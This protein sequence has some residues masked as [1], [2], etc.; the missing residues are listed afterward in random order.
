[1]EREGRVR[2]RDTSARCL[3][4]VRSSIAGANLYLDATTEHVMEM[5]GVA[6]ALR[7]FTV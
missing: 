7:T 4:R 6:H 5:R 3:K 2:E 1:M